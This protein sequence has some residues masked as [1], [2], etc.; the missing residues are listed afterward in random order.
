MFSI[1]LVDDE[2]LA[3]KGNRIIIERSGLD[4]N[5]L[6]EAK[7]GVEAWTLLQKQ[8]VDLVITDIKMPG[9][10]GVTLCQKIFETGMVAKTI[11]VSG[12]SE[13]Q[14][15]K[16]AIRY[17]VKDYILKPVHSEELIQSISSVLYRNQPQLEELD[18]EKHDSIP[19]RELENILVLLQQGLWMGQE[20]D[21]EKGM[22]LYR[23]AMEQVKDKRCLPVSENFCC[24][25][26]E[27]LS[28]K[29]GC[30]IDVEPNFSMSAEREEILNETATFI[31][32][33]RSDLLHKRSHTDYTDVLMGMAKKYLEEHYNQDIMLTDLA[34][35]TGF[36]TNYFSQIFKEKMGKTFA[37]FRTEIRIHKAMELLNWSGKNITD[38]AMEVGY[39]DSTYFIRVFK[40]ITGQTPSEY[41]KKRSDGKKKR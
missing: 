18:L 35:R 41:K 30:L 31:T 20:K 17:S 33:L 6:Y 26:A 19:H 1:L 16:E 15:A 25:L 22:K 12:Y 29:T 34:A 8:P 14:Y 28:L 10:D 40:E 13:F 5:R 11:I 23:A 27:K 32:Q 7:D 38:I 37:Q 39:N 36:S 3:L 2:P 4:I 24:L 21:V 9:M